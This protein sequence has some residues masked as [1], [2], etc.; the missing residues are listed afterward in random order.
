MYSY[1]WNPTTIKVGDLSTYKYIFP[2]P[3]WSEVVWVS[4]TV[5]FSNQDGA[6]AV[7]NQHNLNCW[8]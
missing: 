5:S 2:T 1:F 4:N 7:N 6:V 3:S 8:R